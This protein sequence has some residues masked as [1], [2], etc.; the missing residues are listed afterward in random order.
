MITQEIKLSYDKERMKEVSEMLISDFELEASNIQ[1]YDLIDNYL[2]EMRK[3][4]KK[5]NN[6]RFTSEDWSNIERGYSLYN[7]NKYLSYMF[8]QMLDSS[9]YMMLCLLGRHGLTD[10]EVFSAR[11]GEDCMNLCLKRF[12][13]I[14][15]KLTGTG[16]PVRIKTL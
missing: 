7:S 14:K 10:D 9:D 1:L 8:N 15:Q 4:Y 16:V 13:L 12:P 6:L 2:A 11:S 5:V 3:V